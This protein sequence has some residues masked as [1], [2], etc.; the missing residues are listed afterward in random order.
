MPSPWRLPKG[1]AFLAPDFVKGGMAL[2]PGMGCWWMVAAD[3]GFGSC[4]QVGMYYA[5]PVRSS[6]GLPATSGI[7][8][9]RLLKQFPLGK[10]T[11]AQ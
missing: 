4:Y 11:S 7:G 8:E 1:I 5:D 3:Q 9:E 6:A 2:R 10:V